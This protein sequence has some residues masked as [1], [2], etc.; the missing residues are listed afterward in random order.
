MSNSVILFVSIFVLILLF[1]AF[2]TGIFIGRIIT[3]AS[4]RTR[5]I[6]KLEESRGTSDGKFWGLNE[7]IHTVDRFCN[8]ER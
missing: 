2:I 5:L 3:G 7:A 1:L 8:Y 4:I 6:K